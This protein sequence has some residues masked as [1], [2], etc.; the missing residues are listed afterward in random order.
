MKIF[1]VENPRPSTDD[2]DFWHMS[3]IENHGFGFSI[4]V[5]DMYHSWEPANTRKPRFLT[6]VKN[7]NLGRRPTTEVTD[8]CD[9]WQK[10]G[11]WQTTEFITL[12]LWWKTQSLVD[13]RVCNIILVVKNSSSTND[14][15]FLNSFQN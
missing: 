9:M 14:R 8:T 1:Y 6:F 15:V 10:L 13:D 4:A 3:E 12:F 7:G 11:R 2:R 5:P